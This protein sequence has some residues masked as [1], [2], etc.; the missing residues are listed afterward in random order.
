VSYDSST[1]EGTV[2]LA[3]MMEYLTELMD[4][5]GELKLRRFYVE[6]KN[7]VDF[8]AAGGRVWDFPELWEFREFVES[9]WLPLPSN[10]Q[11]V[12]GGVKDFKRCAA[13]SRNELARSLYGMQRSLGMHAVSETTKEIRKNRLL[14]ANNHVTGGLPGQRKRKLEDGTEEHETAASK[15]IWSDVE[16]KYLTSEIMRQ[17]FESSARTK[18]LTKEE[19]DD[20]TK[21]LFDKEHQ[22]ESKRIDL[23]LEAWDAGR[24]TL[25]PPKAIQRQKP[26]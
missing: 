11:F 2:E 13:T 19:R 26:E 9:K 4:S 14:K 17:V 24:H 8:V 22:F 18:K 1:H 21:K 12:E 20:I 16:G 10:T 15:K 3:A 5:P 25:K 7:S 6:H 23:K